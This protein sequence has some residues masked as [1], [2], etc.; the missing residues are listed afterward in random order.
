MLSVALT[1]IPIFD[2][3]A[4]KEKLCA[5]FQPT[6]QDWNFARYLC[7]RLKLFYDT[8]EI[9]SGT[10]YVTA[11]LFFPKVFAINRWQYTDNRIIEEMSA[12]MK[13]KFMK[14]WIDVNG[15]MAVATVLDPQY[16]MKFFC[17]MYT[18]IY[19]P[20]CMPIKVKKVKD[21][22]VEL[23]K[24][25]QGSMEGFGSTETSVVGSSSTIQNEGDAFVNEIFDAYLSSEPVLPPA[26]VSTEL[27]VYLEEEMLPRTTQLDTGMLLS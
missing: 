3:L 22:L 19:G 11:N 6:E 21:L 1:Y 9:L 26:Y 15:L 14:Y 4:K 24:E 13:A 12:A 23:V 10:S 17:A 16:K 8:T 7:D 25:Y 20:D 2:R 5:P 27:D 18:R